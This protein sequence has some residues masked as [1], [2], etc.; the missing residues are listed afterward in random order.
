MTVSN[1][2]AYTSVSSIGGKKSVKNA[3]PKQETTAICK[4]LLDSARLVYPSPDMRIQPKNLIEIVQFTPCVKKKRQHS[5]PGP[6][7]S[8]NVDIF[9]ATI[10]GT[11]DRGRGPVGCS[12]QSDDMQYTINALDI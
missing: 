11:S 10:L 8:N 4:Q 7:V 6:T 5:L 1:L 3:A 2:I 12:V 9:R